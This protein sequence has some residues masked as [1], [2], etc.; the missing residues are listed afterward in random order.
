MS[1][2][3]KILLIGATF[4]TGNMGVSALT[5]GAIETILRASPN[6]KI[7]L[8]DYGKEPLN[9]RYNSTGGQITVDLL[10]MRFSKRLLLRN[11]IVF[12]IAVSLVARILPCRLGQI[13]TSRNLYLKKINEASV[14]LAI[15]GGDSFSDIYGLRRFFYVSLPQILAQLLRK[16][17]VLLPQTIGP[18]NTRLARIV[19]RSIIRHSSLVYSRD[20]EGLNELKKSVGGISTR[21]HVRFCYDVGFGVNPV[22]PKNID[23]DGF[24]GKEDGRITVGLNVSGLLHMGGYSQNNQ[25]GLRTDYRLLVKRL[26]DWLIVEKN[27]KVILIPHVFGQETG[28]ESDQPV[29]QS[30]YDELGGNYRGGLFYARGTYDQSEIKH[31]IGLC[32]FFIG[33][34]M[35]ACIAALSQGIPTV[36]I[37]YS[38]KFVGVM[39]TIGVE[40]YV[41]D[42]RTMNE[43]EIMDRVDKAWI[44]RDVIRRHLE[45]KIPE[46]KARVLGLFKEIEASL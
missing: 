17:L 2:S 39:G 36:P 13:V 1:F 34:R 10:N 26:I 43:N 15:S 40:S 35:H 11:N 5:A 6:A 22:T 27:A 33:A 4:A 16:K 12:L 30:L 32:D 45:K 23:L 7:D 9:F 25:F 20:Y 3:R 29:C 31:V 42:P 41:A 14:V 37:A 19:A 8:L 24:S 46:V 18:F 38:K 21:E 28:S 44:Q